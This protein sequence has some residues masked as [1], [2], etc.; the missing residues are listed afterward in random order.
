MFHSGD[1]L[2]ITPQDPDDC[3]ALAH[4]GERCQFSR[5][6]DVPSGSRYA[7]VRFST[8]GKSFHFRAGDLARAQAP[9]ELEAR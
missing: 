5:Y 6:V 1:I 7:V 3:E 9:V 2:V 8:Q 4:A